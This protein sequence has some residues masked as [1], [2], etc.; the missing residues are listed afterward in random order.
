VADTA[1]AIISIHRG[2]ANAILAGVK[3]VELRRRI[4]NISPGARLWIYA[5]RPIAA[6]VGFATIEA[7]D[8]ASPEKIWERHRGRSGV[9]H[10]AFQA[11]FEGAPQAVAIL[12][13]A[14][15]QIAPIGID[16]LRRIRDEFHPPQVMTRLTSREASALRALAAKYTKSERSH[17]EAA[18]L[19]L[20]LAT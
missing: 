8:K 20:S 16:Q 2:Y 13:S 3:T 5:T 7:V 17:H 9:D 1:D 4:P 6:I 18:D 10:A 12:L 15:R 11:Y 14:V 19:P